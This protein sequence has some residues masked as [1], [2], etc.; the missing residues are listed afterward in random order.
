MEM[1]HEEPCV[2]SLPDNVKIVETLLLTGRH[3][4][5]FCSQPRMAKG[6]RFGP[7]TGN[8]VLPQEMRAQENN[9][10]WE[11]RKGILRI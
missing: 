7:Y 11:V 8:I 5:V 6:T 3:R 2:Q 4:G 9:S 10:V 1:F